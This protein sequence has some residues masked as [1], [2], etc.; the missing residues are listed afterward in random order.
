MVVSQA[1]GKKI[2]HAVLL[3]IPIIGTLVQEV[4]TARTART[5]SS[6]LSSGVDVVESMNI[7]SGVV[8]NVYFRVV[9]QQA[10][11]A[12][13]KGDLMSKVFSQHEKL[14]PVFFAEMLSVG[15]ETGK[16]GEMLSGVAKYYEEDVDQKTKDMSTVI[17]PFLMIVIG[18]AVGFFAVSIIS[19]MYSLVNAIN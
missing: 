18:A 4:N 12:I 6:L 19:P 10:G 16:I 3:K 5:L 2:I 9:L 8:Q 14:Y 1:L 13:K 7:T 11:E 15:E 17:E